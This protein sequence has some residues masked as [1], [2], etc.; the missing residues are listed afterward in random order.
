MP[1]VRILPVARRASAGRCQVEG[2]GK[3]ITEASWRHRNRK[4]GSC[5]ARIDK[6]NRP[7]RMAF[8]KLKF[9]AR[10]RGHA[11]SLT[12]AQYEKFALE[13]GYAELKGKTGQ[14]LSID[15]RDPSKGYE[16]GNLRAITLSENTR[17]RFLPFNRIPL[18]VE[19]V[20]GYRE[21]ERMAA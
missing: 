6:E 14:S 11:F 4:C 19:I 21:A 13:S 7:L 8:Q 15:R 16:I 18:P 20:D 1:T 12:F 17:I 9:R 3:R 5:R 10:E 2:C